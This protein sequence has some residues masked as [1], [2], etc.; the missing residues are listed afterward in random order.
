[1]VPLLHVRLAAVQLGLVRDNSCAD[2]ALV[3]G[4]ARGRGCWGVLGNACLECTA[5]VCR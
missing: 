3:A 2:N 1:M 4:A 5:D